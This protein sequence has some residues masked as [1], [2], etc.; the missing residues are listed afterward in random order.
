L[1]RNKPRLSI[2]FP[3]Y[4]GEKYL[5]QALD[6]I[7]CQTFMDFELIISDNA[8]KDKTEKI[9]REYI[10]ADDRIVYWRNKTNIGGPAN[11]NHTFRLAQGKYFK[12]TAYDDILAPTYI[13][14]CVKVLDDDPT[15]VLCHSKVS[16]I[17]GNGLVTGNYDANTLY[18]TNSYKPHERFAD[19]ISPLNTCW[20]IHAVM[21]T[22][23]LGK[24]PL[25][26][27]Y[28]DADRNLLAEMGLIGRFYEVPEHLFFR[29]D[30]AGAYTHIYYT[31]A[32]TPNYRE[33]LVWWTGRK[34][35]RLLVLP[36]LKN[37]LEYFNSI[38]RV[39][40]SASER[41][42][43]SREIGR[44]LIRDEGWKMIKWDFDSEFNMLR[45]RLDAF[46]K[47]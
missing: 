19:L 20:A 25:H 29:R 35:F 44:W 27:S 40:L 34:T 38:E 18:N 17:D 4:N 37:C 45:K 32:G 30:H 36:H 14:K 13:E 10:R 28:V 41:A 31:R 46:T 43:C 5:R 15:I 33:Q 23:S 21:R 3:V 11:Y 16:R 1:A 9:C 8:S 7:L 12:W 39:P 26:G 42:L 24:T 22:D 2:G 47:T 6:S